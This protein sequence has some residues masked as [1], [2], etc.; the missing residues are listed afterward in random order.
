MLMLAVVAHSHGA[1][2]LALAT[3]LLATLPGEKERVLIRIPEWDYNW[4]EQYE[5]KEPLKLPKS[6]ILRVRATFGLG[7]G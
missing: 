4:Q 2:G 5:L 7:P 1:D 6:T 3:D